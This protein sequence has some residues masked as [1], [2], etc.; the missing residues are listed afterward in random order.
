M[1]TTLQNGIFLPA[2]GERNCYT[3]LAS[4]WTIL[5]GMIG[6][7]SAHAANLT[8]HVT[9]ADKEA[10]NGKADASALTA[11][12]GDTTIHVTAADKAKWDAV[13]GKADA[14]AL[15]AHTGNT[16]IHVTAA[17]KEA[18]NGKADDSGVVHKAGAETITGEKIFSKYITSDGSSTEDEYSDNAKTNLWLMA[19]RDTEKLSGVLFDTFRQNTAQ[20]TGTHILGFG[21]KENSIRY[22][23]CRF[24]WI[25]D[26]NL[27]GY[28]FSIRPT[29]QG[30]NQAVEHCLGLSTD[31]WDKINGINPGALSLPDLTAGVDISA[32]ITDITGA[33]NINKFTPTADGWISIGLSNADFIEIYIPSSL[34]GGSFTKSTVN[35]YGQAF[36]PVIANKEVRLA[37]KGSSIGWAKFYPCQGNV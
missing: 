37:L 5:D 14:S 29:L 23:G 32:Y 33:S 12:T 3:G 18:W 35:N 24:S 31:K 9:A 8:I 30:T 19:N 25:W 10:W 1:G 16:T 20:G 34:I 28:S 26:N 22:E 36:M 15:T 4:N 21:I 27:N 2:E 17:D 13:T 11:H 6:G 7:Y